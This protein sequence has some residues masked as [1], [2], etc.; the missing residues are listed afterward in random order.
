[1]MAYGGSV[2]GYQDGGDTEGRGFLSGLGSLLTGAGS[3][4]E[5]RDKPL[6]TLGHS[7]LS[8]ASFIPA[9]GVAGWA[10]R[11]ALG[12]AKGRRLQKLLEGAGRATTRLRGGGRSEKLLA[13]LLDPKSARSKTPGWMGKRKIR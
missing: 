10:G 6:R 11:G 12:L 4:E 13:R 1:M 9:V 5:A 7:A 3:W 8:A 2:P